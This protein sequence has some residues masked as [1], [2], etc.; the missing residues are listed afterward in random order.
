MDNRRN[1]TQSWNTGIIC[2]ILKKRNYK[3]I[4]LLNV[5]YRILSSLLSG[6]LAMVTEKIIGEYHCGFHPNG[7]TADQP[8]VLRQMMEQSYEYST[9]LH[10][11]FVDFKTNSLAFSP[12]ANYSTDRTA[13]AGR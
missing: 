6:L 10:M 12:Q 13:A 4:T 3:G 2:P 5:A 9:D 7:S 11:L 1:G 8:F